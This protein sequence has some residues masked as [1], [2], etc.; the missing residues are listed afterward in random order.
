V[1]TLTAPAPLVH[2]SVSSK[3]KK[4]AARELA[5]L[6]LAAVG[7]LLVHGYHPYVEDA[8]IYV[9]GIKRL[10]HPFLYP[11]NSQFFTSHA[12][13][14]LF[15]HLIAASVRFTHIPF[16]WALFC[17]QFF[18]IF[19]LL[20]GCWRLASL[21]FPSAR[22]RWG[23][24]ALVG[25]LLTIPVAGTALYIMD[26]YLTPRA[27]STPAIIFLIVN[28]VERKFLRAGLWAVFIALIHPLMAVFGI[29]FCGVVVVREWGIRPLAKSAAAFLLLP[30]GLFPRVTDDYIISLNRHSYFFVTRWAWYEWAGIFAPLALLWW[31]QRIARSR[32]WRNLGILCQA[33]IAFQLFFLVVSLVLCVPALANFSELQTMRSLHLLYVLLFVFAGGLLAEF[34]FKK[35]ILRWCALFVPLCAGML[36]AQLQLFPGSAH[37]EWPGASSR[38]SWVNAFLWIR[39]NTP[40]NAYF[41]LD[42]RYM[43]ATGEDVQGFRAIAERSSL[44]DEVKDSGAVSMFPALAETWQ[45]QMQALQGW[46]N[47]Q[48]ADFQRLHQKFGV[49]WVVLDQQSS[50]VY[51]G[52]DCPFERDTL[53]VC[54]IPHR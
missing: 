34:V 10:L 48:A 20:L 4:P 2:D 51:R 27:F 28:S 46:R 36:Y 42:P 24:V 5:F 9:P 18:S 29:I 21:C 19:L 8:E 17:W 23:A 7:A 53:R 22:A 15:P 30:M 52:L 14:T 1:A 11:R 3:A 50:S 49:D 40:N 37:V 25:S 38:N 12:G 45:E 32:N 47:F 43:K 54:R 33:L 39:N 13:M 35:N 6:F 41:V 26:Q 44:A 31:F 16:D